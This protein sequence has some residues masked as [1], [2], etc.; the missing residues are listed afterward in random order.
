MRYKPEL[1]SDGI[2]AD[3][4]ILDHTFALIR[5]SQMLWLDRLA[6]IDFFRRQGV[7]DVPKLG[8]KI[9]QFLNSF[10]KEMKE[11]TETYNQLNP[12]KGSGMF[13]FA[14]QMLEAFHN[15]EDP[16]HADWIKFLKA[17]RRLPALVLVSPADFK[18]PRR[19][20]NR[21]K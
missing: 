21:K 4:M 10:P 18:P 3:T 17:T 8:T 6:I 12:A 1:F 7:K 16:L 19:G 5:Q 15:L 20:P 9:A 13:D 11:F 14:N 2:S